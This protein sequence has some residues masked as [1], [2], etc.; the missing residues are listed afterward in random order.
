MGQP[1]AFDASE[2]LRQLGHLLRRATGEAHRVEIVTG[3]EPL[4]IWM[5][6]SQVC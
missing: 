6:P 1:K 2:K 5:D 3:D 4:L